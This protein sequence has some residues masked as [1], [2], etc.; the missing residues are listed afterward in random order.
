MF[1]IFAEYAAFQQTLA[2][3]QAAAAGVSLW[4]VVTS[5]ENYDQLNAVSC[6]RLQREA[7]RTAITATTSLVVC[8]VALNTY[9]FQ[10]G[11]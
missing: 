1:P 3:A 6:R 8:F 11:E 4:L 5:G 10:L 2:L 7:I 9:I